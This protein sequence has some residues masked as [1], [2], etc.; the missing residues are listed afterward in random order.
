MKPRAISP[1][2]N[3]QRFPDPIKKSEKKVELRWSA[4]VRTRQ[5]LERQAA[6]MGFATPA[7]YLHQ[8]IAATLAGNDQ[9]TVV[10]PEGELECAEF[11]YTSD[12]VETGK[13]PRKIG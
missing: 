2:T 13:E 1:V 4:D 8:L 5:A 7:D 6:V 9:S 10:G 3:W 11:A 12:S